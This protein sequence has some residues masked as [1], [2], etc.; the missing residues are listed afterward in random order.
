MTETIPDRHEDTMHKALQCLHMARAIDSRY[1]DPTQMSAEDVA[2]RKAL[3]AEA[4]RLR[5][6]ADTQKAESDLQTWAAAPDDDQHA[7]KSLAANGASKAVQNGGDRFAEVD[8]ALSVK[9]F[10]K[11][12]RAGVGALNLEEKA[13]IIE[14]STG[15][16]IVPADL[17]GP[18]FLTLPRLGVLR[19]LA[20]VRPTGSNRVDVR[21]LTQATAGWGQIE[22]TNAGGATPPTDAAIAATGPNTV[23]VQDLVALVKI[24]VDELMDTDANLVSLVQE[25]VGAQFAQMEDDA[26]A[27]GNG[28]S[29]PF[30]LATRATVGGAIPAA[31]GVTAAASAV[32][33]DQLKSMQYL[34]TSRFANQGVYLASDDATQAI[35]LLKDSTSNYLWEPSNQAGQPDILFGRPFYRMSGLP[36]MVATTFFTE[37]SVLFGDVRSGY[38]IADRQQITVQ[39]LDERYADQGLVGFLFRQ[40]VGGDVIRPSAFAKY[41]L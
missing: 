3:I 34:I 35:A 7:L 22:I 21:A 19:N 5:E 4:G 8:K 33:P 24:G 13:A 2:N 30:G 41:L 40:R 32:N 6:I 12:L 9:R 23:S 11:A 31:Q 20:L 18:I 16:I 25:I 36:S 15:Q 38:M 29:K 26:F 10:A 28:T 27:N 39:R 17:A 14:D 1:P 37:P